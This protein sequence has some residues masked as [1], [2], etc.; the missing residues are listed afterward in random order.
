MIYGILLV[1]F[2]SLCKSNGFLIMLQILF[3]QKMKNFGHGYCVIKN[4]CNFA[5]VTSKPKQYD[6]SS[7]LR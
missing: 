5:A 4:M 7:G 2:F 6:Q 1:L 3:G